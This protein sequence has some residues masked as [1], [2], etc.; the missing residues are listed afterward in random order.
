MKSV[1]VSVLNFNGRKNTLECVESLKKMDISDFKLTVL[2]IDNNSS[3]KLNL[4][5]ESV[6]KIE[7][8]VIKNEKNLGF[9][10]GHNVGIKYALEN[11]ADYVLILNNDTYVDG[12]FLT[13]LFREAEKN[14]KVGILVPKIFFAPGFEYHKDRYSKEEKGK[15]LW[16]A[17][18]EM[19]WGNIVGHNRGVDEADKGQYNKIEETELA[20]GCCM[21]IKKDVFEKIGSFDDR[22]FLYYEDADLSIRAKK[23][24]FKIVYVPKSVIWHKNAGSVGGSGSAL[25]DY[26]ITRNRLIFGFR[27]APARSKLALFRESICLLLKG[28]KWQK[29][30][31][32]DFYLGRLGK[33]SYD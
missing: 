12:N 5:N 25:Q 1:F 7:L 2:I 3:E 13:E 6:G 22:Y 29:Q 18:G 33:G 17:G 10:G 24:G 9:S 14:S 19:D 8:K 20:T 28:R 30:G 4:Q 11:A 27:Y 21:L 26:Y 32:M 31:A 23:R 15:I 16:Y